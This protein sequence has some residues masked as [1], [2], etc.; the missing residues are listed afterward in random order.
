MIITELFED[1]VDTVFARCLDP[2][3][4]QYTLPIAGLRSLDEHYLAMGREH[5]ALARTMDGLRAIGRFLEP[6]IP[7]PRD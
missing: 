1:E 4:R 6:R 3:L 5:E 2:M 7:D